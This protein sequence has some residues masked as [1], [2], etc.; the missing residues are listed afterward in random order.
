MKKRTDNFDKFANQTRGSAVKE[1]FRQEKKKIKQEARA[2]GEEMRQ[3]KLDKKRGID[4]SDKETKPQQTKFRPQDKGKP[5]VPTKKYEVRGTKKSEVRSEKSG[6]KNQNIS[7]P[8]TQTPYAK[9]LPAQPGP[10]SKLTKFVLH[11]AVI[12][13]PPCLIGYANSAIPLKNPYLL[14]LHSICLATRLPN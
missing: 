1:A 6:V 11:Q 12:Q 10:N 14:Y 8:T 13:N 2:A 5:G 3:K 7:N 4:T 9:L